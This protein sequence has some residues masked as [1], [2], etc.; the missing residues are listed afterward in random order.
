MLSL[1]V[2]SCH[3]ALSQIE[4]S[5]KINH[6]RRKV[7]LTSSTSKKLHGVTCMERMEVSSSDDESLPEKRVRDAAAETL[8]TWAALPDTADARHRFD[9]HNSDYLLCQVAGRSIRIAQNR[10]RQGELGVTGCCVWDAAVVL[11]RYLEWAE[12][13]RSGSKTEVGVQAVQDAVHGRKCLELGAGCGL[14]GLAAAAL[15]GLVT[16]TDREETLSLLE[17]NVKDFAAEHCRSSEQRPRRKGK[18]AASA[19]DMGAT[20]RLECPH[21]EYLDWSEP[22]ELEQ[23][24]GKPYEVILAADCLYSLDGAAA[25]ASVV[26]SLCC[27]PESPAFRATVMLSQEL[28]APETLK[29]NMAKNMWKRRAGWRDREFYPWL[30]TSSATMLATAAIT[31]AC[32]VAVPGP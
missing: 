15:G 7:C 16:V 27:E 24:D 29:V 11:A 17:R 6:A 31:G 4:T 2:S 18:V 26:K 12:E 1:E 22:L 5:L 30:A 19:V 10:A 20:G 3:C 25:L 9:D 23:V 28:R 8:V 21:A 14:A 32:C 13:L